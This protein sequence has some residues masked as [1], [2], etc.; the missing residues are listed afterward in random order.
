M[1]AHK[2]IKPASLTPHFSALQQ[3]RLEPASDQPPLPPRQDPARGL[4]Q[5]LPPLH[6]HPTLQSGEQQRGGGATGQQPAIQQC[7]E[8]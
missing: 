1:F 7:Q 2:E 4:P 6:P 8:R 5:P 3:T